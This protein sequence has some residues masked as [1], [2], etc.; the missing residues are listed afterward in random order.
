M[1]DELQNVRTTVDDA[2]M[3]PAGVVELTDQV[4]DVASVNAGTPP[5]QSWNW[6]C[7]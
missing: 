7:F 2:E 6:D 1:K 3:I 4:L 5:P